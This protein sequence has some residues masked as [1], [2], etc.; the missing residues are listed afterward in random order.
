MATNRFN[1]KQDDLKPNFMMRLLA[2]DTPLDLTL[3]S[4]VRFYMGNRSG[5]VVEGDM[6]VHDQ[7]IDISRGIVEYAWRPGDTDTVG[8]FQAEI[9]VQW[10]D[11]GLQTFP[12][13][14]YI[15]IRI[16]KDLD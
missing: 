8:D 14:S 6:I 3:A 9:E 11:G 16:Q 1:I 15:R 4:Q 13:S 12:A 10:Q 5:L 2:G 7:S